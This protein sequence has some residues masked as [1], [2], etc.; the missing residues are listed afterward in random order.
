DFAVEQGGN[1]MRC[2][3]RLRFQFVGLFDTVASVGLAN[4]APVPNDGGFMGSANDP[5]RT[6][7]VWRTR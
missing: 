4:S 1:R 7:Q 5:K 3:P 2:V 6:T